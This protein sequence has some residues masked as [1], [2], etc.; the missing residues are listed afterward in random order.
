MLYFLSE[1]SSRKEG[2]GDMFKEAPQV[3]QMVNVVLDDE[4]PLQAVILV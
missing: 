3:K 4:H 2:N 1:E